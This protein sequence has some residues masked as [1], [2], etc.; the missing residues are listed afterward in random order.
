MKRIVSLLLLLTA[1]G[2]QAGSDYTKPYATVR[3]NITAPTPPPPGPLHVALVW[4]AVHPPLGAIEIA[5]DVE[6]A[7]QFPAQFELDITSLPPAN[8]VSGFVDPA[9]AASRGLDPN[10]QWA[11]AALLVYVDGN[12]NGVL[13]M[14]PQGQTSPDQVIGKAEGVTLWFLAQGSPAP[15]N[16]LGALP[17]SD[18]FSVTWAPYVDPQPGD[19]SYDDSGGHYDFECSQ[20]FDPGRTEL[21]LPANVTITLG[22]DPILTNYS[23]DTFW[24][25][26]DWPDWASNWNQWSALAQTVCS[27]P[28]CDCN[29]YACPL[30]LPPAGISVTCNADGTAFTWKKCVSDPDV[31]GTRFCHYGHGER[32]AAAPAPTGWPCS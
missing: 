7:P 28:G 6:V 22:T 15:S 12:G 26:D 2:R 14:M 16:Y 20:P 29:G 25:S 17:T 19:C 5:Q 4:L 18:G 8:A 3:G 11:Q 27:G 24:G 21:A 30:D 13:D 10:M 9:D 23:C 32:D 1:C 31:C